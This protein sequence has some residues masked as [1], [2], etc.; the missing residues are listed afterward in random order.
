MA[1]RTDLNRFVAALK[2]SLGV[3]V[4]NLPLLYQGVPELETTLNMLYITI[5]YPQEPLSTSESRD[6]F[7]SLVQKV[8]AVLA[9]IHSFALFLDDLHDAPTS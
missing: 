1:L 6:R 3:Q 7:F 8:F 4:Q 9:K 5:E 2:D